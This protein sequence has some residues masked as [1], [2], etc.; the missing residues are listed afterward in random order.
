MEEKQ[1]K[2]SKLWLKILLI[3]AIITGA[4]AGSYCVYAEQ[5]VSRFIEGT[6]INGINVGNQTAEEVEEQIRSKVEN[7]A[8]KVTFGDGTEETINGADFGFAYRSDGKVLEILADQN[9]YHWIQGK[10]FGSTMEFTVGEAFEYDENQLKAALEAL[11]EL[12]PENMTAPQNAYMQMGEDNRFAVIPENDG[13]TVNE[14][15][16]FPALNETVAN[17]KTA[18]D[19]RK[20]ENVYQTALVRSD[21]VDLNNQVNLLNNFLGTTITYQLHDGSQMVLDAAITKNWLT[22]LNDGANNYTIDGPTI[23]NF[24]TQYVAEIA[25][26]DDD[27]KKTTT[28]HSSNK[29]DVELSCKP[30][31]HQVNQSAEAT[32]LYAALMEFRSE[33]K[34]PEYSINSENGGFGNLF[35]EIDIAN[36]HVYVHQGDQVIFDSACVT[37]TATNP[38][39]A[40]PKGVFQIFWKTT[41]RNLRGAIDPETGQPSYI[42]HVNFWMPF[43]GGVGMH[44]ASWRSEYGGSIYQYSGSHGCVNLPYSAAAEIYSLVSV[45]TYV[46]VL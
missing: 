44:D 39:R 22:P 34:A 7:Y 46:I 37:G 31:G 13:T 9:K 15:V 8:V 27:V 18:L 32:A 29:G 28:F 1:K 12:Q 4:L 10:L 25:A 23:Q 41:D 26:K 45:G 42:S 5:Y 20:M 21:N 24:A 38:S 33:T 40:T 19:L 35:V 17:G 16:I 43:N 2:G 11:P 6:F 3:C 14:D 30:Y 36:Q